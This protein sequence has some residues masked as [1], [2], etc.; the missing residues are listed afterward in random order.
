[1]VPPLEDDADL[2]PRLLHPLLQ[3]HELR[4]HPAELAF[5]LLALHLREA[6]TV[7]VQRHD[8]RLLLAHARASLDGC[9]PTR[10]RGGVAPGPAPRQLSA[11]A[12]ACWNSASLNTPLSRRSA[13]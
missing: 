1:A 8:P 7:G 9:G 4:I 5:V 12:F 13:R 11:L 3:R 2:R 10:S 6:Q